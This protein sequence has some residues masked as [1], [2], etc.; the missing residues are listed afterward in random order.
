VSTNGVE[1][2]FGRLKRHLRQSGI[3]KVSKRC[4]AKYLVEFLWGE[5]YLSH[6]H[7][8]THKW[9]PYAFFLLCRA[10]AEHFSRPEQPI[11]IPNALIFEDLERTWCP[12]VPAEARPLAFFR[13]SLRQAAPGSIDL[14]AE[15]DCEMVVHSAACL[16]ES[17]G[18]SV[19]VAAV[20]EVVAAGK[21][22][23]ETS[24]SEESDDEGA[25]DAGI[26][27]P[28]T[29]TK[30]GPPR[31]LPSGRFPPRPPT[32]R[33]SSALAAALAVPDP[34]VELAVENFI[35]MQVGKDFEI[36]YNGGASPGPWRK[37]RVVKVSPFH[38]KGYHDGSFKCFLRKLI[39][40]AKLVSEVDVVQRNVRPRTDCGPGYERPVARS[41][42]R[43]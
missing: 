39:L 16:P 22:V 19:D 43:R 38:I 36:C 32:V 1:G 30:P 25:S 10:V 23:S 18:L 29:S 2:L 17:V 27:L 13:R 26:E 21:C 14:D 35:S 9:S 3:T 12:P 24:S 5:K 15:S 28:E 41:S 33:S 42:G 40:D 37:V 31:R 6:R 20:V 11:V 34:P 7:L 4:Y 8:G